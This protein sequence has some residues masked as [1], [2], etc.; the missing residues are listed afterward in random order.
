[1]QLPV[2]PT[3]PLL[4]RFGASGD[5]IGNF[6]AKFLANFLECDIGVFNG[7]VQES[8]GNHSFRTV[9][10]Q[11]DKSDA[12]WMSYIRHFANFPALLLV[13]ASGEPYSPVDQ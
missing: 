2:F 10:P 12:D 1:M 6:V 9:H 3:V 8:G 11:E 4:G 5:D 13:G 7:V